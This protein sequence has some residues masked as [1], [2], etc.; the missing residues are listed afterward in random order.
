MAY[1]G[2]TVSQSEGHHHPNTKRFHLAVCAAVADNIASAD[3]PLEFR[4]IARPCW[5]TAFPRGLRITSGTV[6]QQASRVEVLLRLL[7]Q[8]GNE[9]SA[10]WGIQRPRL[11]ELSHE[12]RDAFRT[13]DGIGHVDHVV[14]E[15]G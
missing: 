13:D 2:T 3:I 5:V 10:A 1:R 15:I 11:D 12:R 4:L 7:A 6:P 9:C 8:R 14:C